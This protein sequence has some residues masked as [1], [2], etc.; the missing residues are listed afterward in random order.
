[1]QVMR[2]EEYAAAARLQAQGSA[3]AGSPMNQ[4][5]SNA[6]LQNEYYQRAAAKGSK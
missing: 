4:H 3:E 1:M 6:A 2:S 5:A